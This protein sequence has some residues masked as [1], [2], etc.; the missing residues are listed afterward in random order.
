MGSKIIKLIF[1]LVIFPV[2]IHAQGVAFRKTDTALVASDGGQYRIFK[3]Q[4]YYSTQLG[5]KMRYSDTTTKVVTRTYGNSNYVRLTTDQTIAGVKTFSSVVKGVTPVANVDLTTKLYVDGQ[6]GWA[7]YTDNAKTVGAPLVIN[8]GVTTT[9]TNNAA[10]SIITQ[11]PVGVT[12]FYDSVNSKI[13]PQNDGDFYAINIRFTA[14]SSSTNGLFDLSLDIGS[15][16]NIIMTETRILNKGIGAAQRININFLIY[17]G[18]T[19][20]TNGGLIKLNSIT[21][22]TSIYDIT[23]NISRLHKAR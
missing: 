13:T 1:G 2:M 15:P 3:S 7:I 18:S 8:A 16:M 19:F 9:I 4:P 10:T 5:L 21:G 17:S 23:Y 22:N 20:V 6:T 11:L 12:S 14:S